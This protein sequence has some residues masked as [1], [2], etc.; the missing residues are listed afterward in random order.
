[1]GTD[2]ENDL[3][4]VVREHNRLNGFGLVMVEFFLV[5]L[6]ALLIAI[7][8]IVHGRILLAIIGVG[9]GVN[10]ITVI[11]ITAAQIR[12]HEQSEGLLKLR[13]SEFRAS[14]AQKNPNLSRH[15]MLVFVSTLV[16]FLLV[17]LLLL[18]RDHR[19]KNM[20]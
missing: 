1:M 18:Q 7:A 2:N 9:I 17:A 4:A 10:A 3:L 14:L 12:D 8:G 20:R 13:S 16:P 11:T 19:H 6:A 5:T 15:T